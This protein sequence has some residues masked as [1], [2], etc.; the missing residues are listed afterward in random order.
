MKNSRLYSDI[1]ENQQIND[2]DDEQLAGYNC[3]VCG[4]PIVIES[5]LEVCYRCGWSKDDECENELDSSCFATEGY[6][7]Q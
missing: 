6:F 3:P 4:Y 1:K 5:G 2:E 7:V